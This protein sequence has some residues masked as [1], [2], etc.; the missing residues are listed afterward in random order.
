M[1]CVIPAN[2]P[3]YQ[4]L[5]DKAASYPADKTYQV[6]AY[7]KAAEYV[8]AMKDSIYD[9]RGKFYGW[10]SPHRD[11]GIGFKI[12]EFINE[13]L[14]ANPEPKILTGAAKAMDDARKAAAAAAPKNVTT[15]PD[16]DAARAAFLARVAS[17]RDTDVQKLQTTLLAVNGQPPKPSLIEMIALTSTIHT[18]PKW[19]TIDYTPVTYTPENPRRSKRNIRK[20]IKKYFDEQDDITEAIEDICD[21]K[22]WVYSDDLL[23]DFNAWLPTAQQYELEKYNYRTDRY[24]PKTKPELAKEWTQY[25]SKNIQ[26][27]KRQQQLNKAVAKYCQKH[28]FE[29]S[30]LMEEKFAQWMADPANKKLITKT[31]PINSCICSSCDPS[32]EK[33]NTATCNDYTYDIGPSA[34]VAKWLSTLKKVVV[35]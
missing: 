15:W 35:F 22:G 34:C 16:D 7:N 14:K 8:A 26:K 11:S 24:E 17:S 32:G 19:S 10:W 2:Q 6:K 5:L 30:P 20:P 23:T 18:E 27:Q 12:E 9:E 4:A 33:K 31:Y 28:G 3:I 29:Y 13:F 21:K 25:I 1:S